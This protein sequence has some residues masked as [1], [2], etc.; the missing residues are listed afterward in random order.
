[1]DSLVAWIP[2]G[3]LKKQF[4]MVAQKQ[5]VGT[6]IGDH[7]SLINWVLILFLIGQKFT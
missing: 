2:F 7:D 3:A 5:F 1:M 4:Y 6:L